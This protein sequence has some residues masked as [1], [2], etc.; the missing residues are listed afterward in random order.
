MITRVVMLCLAALLPTAVSAQSLTLPGC[1]VTDYGHGVYYLKCY[2]V[3]PA[4]AKLRELYPQANFAISSS[5]WSAG[6]ISVG[7]TGYY[8][9]LNPP[10]TPSVA[11]AR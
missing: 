7:T 4:L 6:S 9:V 2:E 3:G 10:S 11:A 5:S 8:V 1:A